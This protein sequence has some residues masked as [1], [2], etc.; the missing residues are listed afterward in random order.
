MFEPRPGV[1]R[2]RILCVDDDEQVLK[3]LVTV[4]RRRFD[5]TTADNGAAAMKILSE[6]P[7]FAIVLSDFLMPGMNGVTLLGH[8][9][10]LAPRA[11]R[12]LFTGQ[13]GIRDELAS[14]KEQTAFRVL[15]KPLT[16]SELI[17]ELEKA[18]AQGAQTAEIS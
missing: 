3:S 5:I 7:S 11:V 18:L 16:S 13:L 2:P 9:A 8:V 10:L 15:A 4:L 12:I 14:V 17:A 6:N 1:P